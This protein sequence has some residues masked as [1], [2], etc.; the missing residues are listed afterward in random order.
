MED[1]NA[2]FNDKEEPLDCR[3][4]FVPRLC[5]VVVFRTVNFEAITKGKWTWQGGKKRSVIDYVLASQGIAYSV[6]QMTVD[7]ER[8]F[9]IGSDHN[10]IFW[11]I[12]G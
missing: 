8:W 10:L 12:R 6:T 9:D 2:H 4:K 5:E 1:F 11:E 3:A 7:D